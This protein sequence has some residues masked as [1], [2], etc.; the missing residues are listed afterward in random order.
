MDNFYAMVMLAFYVITF[1]LSIV[2]PFFS[3]GR[4]I[5]IGTGVVPKN[6]RHWLE[7]IDEGLEESEITGIVFHYFFFQF[8]S[9]TV[10]L[11]LAFFWPLVLVFFITRYLFKK[12][13]SKSNKTGS[14][15]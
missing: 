8:F 14:N 10:L 4:K 13:F 12:K 1:G 15:L 3:T 2:L 9:G 7:D 6:D 5:L 11:I